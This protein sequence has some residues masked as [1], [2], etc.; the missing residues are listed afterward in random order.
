MGVD[1]YDQMTRLYSV[2][3]ASRRWPVHVFYYVLDMALINSWIL[4]K[5]VC[6]SSISRREFMQRV[7][8]KLTGSPPI[9]SRKRR[10]EEVCS[11]NNTNA[12]SIVKR[13]LTC[14]TLKCRNWTTDMFQECNKPV[15]EMFH[16]KVQIVCINTVMCLSNNDLA[17][18]GYQ[19]RTLIF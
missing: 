7:A 9:V 6:Q 14:S 8:E 2:K 5:Q 1:L 3:A 18:T 11:P 19:K 4:Y 12:S 17:F 15:W 13:R 10:A 16:H